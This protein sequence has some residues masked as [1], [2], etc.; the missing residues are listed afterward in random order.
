MLE[1]ISTRKI[2]C[3]NTGLNY[4][5][6]LFTLLN[7]A[8]Q[9]MYMWQAVVATCMTLLIGATNSSKLSPLSLNPNHTSTKLVNT[10]AVSL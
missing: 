4:M 10:A 9:K 6:Y 2:R 3:K 1:I 5:L 8:S 7:T